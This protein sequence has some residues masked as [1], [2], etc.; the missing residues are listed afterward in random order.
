MGAAFYAYHAILNKKRVFTQTDCY[1]GEDFTSSEIEKFLKSQKLKYTKIT[2][3]EKLV[4]LLVDTLVQDK[5]I[6]FFHGR[7]E[8]GPRALGARSIVASPRKE[9]MKEIVNT[10]IKFRELTDRLLR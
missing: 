7:S 5:A 8:W 2:S 4:S 10:K 6:G 9:E 3:E 1:F